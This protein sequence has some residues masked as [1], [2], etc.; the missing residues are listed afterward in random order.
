MRTYPKV[1]IIGFVFILFYLLLFLGTRFSTLQLVGVLHLFDALLMLIVFVSLFFI[2]LRIKHKHIIFI[3]TLSCLYFIISLSNYYT[4]SILVR[5]YALFAYM[6]FAYI[7]F[8]G[9]VTN[10]TYFNQLMLSLKRLI[11]IG[12]FAQILYLLTLLLIG[13][14]DP[15]EYNYLSPLVIML[16]IC[17]SAYAFS[18]SKGIVLFFILSLCILVSLSLGHSSAV[19]PIVIISFSHF[20]L[21]IR[22][23]IIK[24]IVFVIG[25]FFLIGAILFIPS[26]SDA[27]A[28]WR[29]GYWYLI[30]NDLVVS[31]YSIFGNGF[32]VPY[33]TE[34][35]A[36]Y[37]QVVQGATT[38]LGVG[39]ES[40][41]AASH[42]SFLTICFHI[43]LLPGLLIFYP[44]IQ[45][46][47]KVKYNSVSRDYRFLFLCLIGLMVWSSFNVILE[48]PHSSLFF[49]LIYFLFLFKL[50]YIKI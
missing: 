38:G 46:V 1:I 15:E 20:F 39:D 41:L 28:I 14:Y 44:V 8:I 47:R 16:V 3:F 42:N 50:K 5:Q 18:F 45:F 12:L 26:F 13:Q 19:L 21:N 29:L 10:S 4:F 31:K 40:Y 37:L 36:Y 7:L 34:E 43:G 23:L 6:A 27:N 35:I 33:A 2:R 30:L 22:F 24:T 9:L 32:G 11:F 25:V 17:C 48:L 49:W